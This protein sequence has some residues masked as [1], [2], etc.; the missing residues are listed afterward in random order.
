MEKR[1][2]QPNAFYTLAELSTELNIGRDTLRRW[3]RSGALPAKR[4]GKKWW[5]AGQAVLD[6]LS[7]QS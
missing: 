7:S 5:I 6:L 3:I 2:I 4:V 1:G